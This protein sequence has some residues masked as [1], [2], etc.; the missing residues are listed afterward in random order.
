MTFSFCTGP[1]FRLLKPKSTGMRR[2]GLGDLVVLNRNFWP[3]LSWEFF[4]RVQPVAF[5]RTLVGAVSYNDNH[6]MTS[7]NMTSI[8]NAHEATRGAMFVLIMKW[9]SFTDNGEDCRIYMAVSQRF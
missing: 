7:I 4:F 6:P 3:T 1:Y 5:Q 2:E 8:S 9:S